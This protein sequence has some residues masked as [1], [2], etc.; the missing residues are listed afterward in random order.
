MRSS[1]SGRAGGGTDSAPRSALG[2]ASPPPRP[3]SFHGAEI[4]FISHASGYYQLIVQF[5]MSDRLLG[6]TLQYR[7]N[8]PA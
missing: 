1:R 3:L 7:L 8:R 2:Y 4:H 6:V 5:T